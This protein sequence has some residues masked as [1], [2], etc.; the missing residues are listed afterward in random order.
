[1]CRHQH[2]GVGPLRYLWVFSVFVLM[3]MEGMVLADKLGDNLPLCV[4][5]DVIWRL[6]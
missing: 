5:T 6:P 2:T 4:G 1:M 3:H